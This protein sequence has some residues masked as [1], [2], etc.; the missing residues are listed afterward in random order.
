MPPEQACLVSGSREASS[1]RV[2]GDEG[3]CHSSGSFR[4]RL[5][6]FQ[7]AEKLGGNVGATACPFSSSPLRSRRR[8]STAARIVIDPDP[9]STAESRDRCPGMCDQH[10]FSACRPSPPTR[11][12]GCWARSGRRAP[13]ADILRRS[14][15]GS[16][17]D[18]SS[19]PSAVKPHLP[20]EAEENGLQ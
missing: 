11:T 7:I 3:S 6:P 15:R 17:R 10:V 20:V 19:R 5:Q 12:E 8:Q 18:I 13:G 2:E 9:P 16:P 14:D 4:K 1:G